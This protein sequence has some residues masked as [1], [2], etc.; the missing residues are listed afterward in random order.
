MMVPTTPAVAWGWTNNAAAGASVFQSK[1]TSA[2]NNANKII[3][4]HSG[5]PNLTPT[6]LENMALL[7]Y[8]PFAPTMNQLANQYYI[9]A[10][11]GGAWTWIVNTAN[12][13][14]GVAY[15]NSCR[16]KTQ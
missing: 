4:T 2:N 5:L 11:V 14:N 13:P 16:A 7:L 15:A 9:P 3:A 1:L 10:E 8:G 12:N 6:Q